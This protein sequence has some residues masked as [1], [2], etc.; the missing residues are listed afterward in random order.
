[1]AIA[2]FVFDVISPRRIENASRRL[3][4]EVDPVRS[5][6]TRGSLEEFLR[7][8]N[9]IEASLNEA[10][11]PFQQSVT[12]SFERVRPRHISNIRLAEI[13]FRNKRIDKL[14]FS[15]LRELIILRNSII[16]GAEPI[17]SRQAVAMSEDV[18]RRLHIALSENNEEPE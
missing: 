9:Q 8:Y 11:A 6:Q 5:E 4:D 12:S 3:Q 14:L 10:G 7:N 1:M 15:H 16:H 17:V 2:Y 18:L 13:L